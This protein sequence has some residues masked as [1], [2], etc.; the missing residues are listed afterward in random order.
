MS[1]PTLLI[2]LGGVGNV[3]T[4]MYLYEYEGKILI[5]D[6]GI[7]FPQ[8]GS[9]E[10]VYVP[11]ISYL[12][13]REH[14][15]VAMVLTH[16]HDDHIAALP[17]IIPQLGNHFPI[18]AAPLTQGF[19]KDRVEDYEVTLNF[20]PLPRAPHQVGPFTIHGVAV[21]HSVPDTFHV[22]VTTPTG[23]IYHG[24]DFKFDLNP[25]DGVL[26]D[27]QEMSRVGREGVMLLLSDSLNSEVETFSE[28]ESTLTDMF[29]REMNNVG[30]KILVT[31]MS[32]NIHRIQQV[33]NIANEVGRKVVFVGRSVEQNVTTALDLGYLHAKENAILPKHRLNKLHPHQVCVVIAGSQGQEQSS[34]S[35]AAQG[36]HKL[37]TI[38]PQ[39]KVIFASEAIPGNEHNVYG[40][41]DMLARTGA[42]VTY[43]D[44][45][46]SV[47]VSGHSSALEQKLL[48]AMTKPKH[49]TPIGGNYRHMIQYRS[50]ARSLGYRDDKIHLL[51]NGMVV[52]VTPEEVKVINQLDL[53]QMSVTNQ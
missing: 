7:G 39:D 6:C 47:H 34:L 16:G 8:D 32:S 11:D 3:N 9:S 30:G 27:F 42:D 26:P 29:R 23:T 22:V 13:G 41:I 24:S 17:Y 2:P 50:L 14:D 53:Q 36:I 1:S 44:I 45:D 21:T 43:Y 18:F 19:A 10:Y 28:S 48:I 49:L 46:T 20:E 12:K 37:V 33:L 15:I 31:V 51:D 4:N 38:E 40:A 35:R 5:V 52:S 25:I